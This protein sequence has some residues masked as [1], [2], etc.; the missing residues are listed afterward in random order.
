MLVLHK[1]ASSACAR[2][3]HHMT[4]TAGGNSLIE[5][6]RASAN[7]SISSHV[8]GS[9]I[10]DAQHAHQHAPGLSLVGNSSTPAHTRVCKGLGQPPDGWPSVAAF[11]QSA[12]PATCAPTT[13][14]EGACPRGAVSH[15]THGRETRPAHTAGAKLT[16]VDI[17]NQHYLPS[18]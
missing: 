9:S 11:W 2:P 16:L 8:A 1:T 14:Y 18:R 7:T 17:D 3:G 10:F 12:T 5:H 4:R 15:G 6:A 13:G